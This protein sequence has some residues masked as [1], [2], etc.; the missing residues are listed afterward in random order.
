MALF[1]KS[2]GSIEFEDVRAF[3]DMN[4]REGLRIDY[5]SDFPSD[6]A[7]IVIAFAN[8]AGGIIL[9]GIRANRQ[10]NRPE[11]IVGVELRSGIEERVTDIALSN[12]RPPILPE[13]KVCP[14]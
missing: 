7:K 12:I 6:L 10:T 8:T 3:F 13:I 11:E 9:I 1:T 2:M 5:K 14:Y 4:L